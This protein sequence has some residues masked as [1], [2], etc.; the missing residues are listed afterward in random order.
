[1]FHFFSV[2]SCTYTQT[3]VGLQMCRQIPGRTVTPCTIRN[4]T[5]P[6]STANITAH[7]DLNCKLSAVQISAQ[8]QNSHSLII[9]TKQNSD[10]SLTHLGVFTLNTAHISNNSP[11]TISMLRLGLGQANLYAVP[12]QMSEH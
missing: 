4:E 1:M 12:C 5:R 10:N 8:F 3:C 2:P 9:I 11:L 7:F 6:S